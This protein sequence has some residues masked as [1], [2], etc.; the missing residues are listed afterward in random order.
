MTEPELQPPVTNDWIAISGGQLP[1][2]NAWRWVG[3]PECG[4]IVTFCGTVRDHSDGRAGVT[5][6]EYEAYEEHVV[7]RLTQVATDAR[8][9]WPEIGRLALLHR[10]GRLEVGEVAVVVAV[11]TPH[12]AE[13]FAA[14]QFC[15]DTL[16]HTIPIWKRETWEGGSDWSVCAQEGTEPHAHGS[17]LVSAPSPTGAGE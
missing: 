11:S 5:S 17:S 13:A 7:P 2:D 4:G 6:L 3:L 8:D 10:V 16:K 12:R 9:R 14:A 1:V 15:I